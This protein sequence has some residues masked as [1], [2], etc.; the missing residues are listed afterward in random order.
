MER[1]HLI[2]LVSSTAANQ[3]AEAKGSQVRGIPAIQARGS[4]SVGLGQRLPMHCDDFKQ[5]SAFRGQL[6]DAIAQ[7]VFQAR[8]FQN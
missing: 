5:T 4:I 2:F 3:V 7:H 1:L 6:A 8:R